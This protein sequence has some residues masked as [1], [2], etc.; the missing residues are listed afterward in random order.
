MART[1][2]T[3]V[4]AILEEAVAVATVDEFITS[5]NLVVTNILGTDTTLSDDLKADIERYLAAHFITSTIARMAAQAG[6]GPAPSVKFTGEWK[7]GLLSTPYGQ[8]VLFLDT[9][10]KMADNDGRKRASIRA[11]TSPNWRTT[12]RGDY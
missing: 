7:M 3:K 11:A 9:T 10:G 5:A 8:H 6:G 12:L 4:N 1:T 2:A